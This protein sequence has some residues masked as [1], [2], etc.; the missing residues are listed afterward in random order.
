MGKFT[1]YLANQGVAVLDSVG[2]VV[3]DWALQK[4][5]LGKD[6]VRGDEAP[7]DPKSL[8]FDPYSIVEQLG[9]KDKPTQISY[10]TLRA[11]LRRLPI[12][13]AI[14]ITRINQVVSFCQP[15]Y[16]R[17][18]LGFRVK[19]KDQNR[20]ST[21]I[22]QKESR[23]LE[24]IIM[25][26]GYTHNPRG[27]DDFETFIKKIV[28]DSMTFDQLCFEIVPNRKGKP[29]EWY[30]VDASTIRKA[31]NGTPYYNEDQRA[32]TKYVQIYDGMIISEYGQEELCFGVRN[33]DTNIR[34]QGYGVSE[35]EM[36]ITIITSLLYAL[37]FN[38]KFFTQGSAAKGI[39]NFKGT[40]PERQLQQFRR[41]WYQMLAGV[42]NAWR[43]PITNSEDL[44]YINLQATHRDMEFN[45]YMDFLIKVACSVYAIDPVEVNFKYG[46]VGQKG[47]LAEASNK[48][49]ITESKE[50]GLRPLLRHI[51]GCIDKYIINPLNPDF[52]FEFVG[53]DAETKSDVVERNMKRVK[54]I[55]TVDE[56]RAEED[57]PPLPDGKGEVIL[58]NTWLQ[59]MQQKEAELQQEGQEKEEGENEEGEKEKEDLDFKQLLGQYEEEDED[60]DDEDEEEEK[61]LAKS[62]SINWNME[63]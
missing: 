63:L 56:L 53:L 13:Q 24:N 33:P 55:R 30:A 31:D 9:Y 36:L 46:N 14:M 59:F 20:N 39:I 18:E 40:I 45:S 49:K 50:R 57:L 3:Q 2:K 34:L 5:E 17:Y 8:F 44:Q 52:Y 48:D 61:S 51:S 10:G 21:R 23:N 62:T 12:V 22:E 27:R 25:T 4:A 1:D 38:Q 26:T 7:Q 43:T 37:D 41:H 29:A 19:M 42:E 54:S 15:Q 11:V 47:A 28:R 32:S 58:D 6:Y 60:E 35:L 16:D